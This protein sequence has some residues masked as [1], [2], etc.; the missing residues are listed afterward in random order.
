MTCQISDI[1]NLGEVSIKFNTIMKN[2]FN[3]SLINEDII[4]IY[5]I[6]ATETLTN[7]RRLTELRGRSE[8]SLDSTTSD[9]S[10]TT[11]S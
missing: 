5:I 8:N 7:N 4:D 10:Q 3:I 11:T 1:S 2:D 9:S 6:P